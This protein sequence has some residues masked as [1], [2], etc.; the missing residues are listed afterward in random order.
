MRP[1]LHTLIAL[2][3]T[4]DFIWFHF[5]CSID[6]CIKY[7]FLRHVFLTVYSFLPAWLLL[8]RSLH[9]LL[10]RLFFF[11][12]P[13]ITD[14]CLLRIGDNFPLTFSRLTRLFPFVNFSF[15]TRCCLIT[16]AWVR[17]RTSLSLFNYMWFILTTL[18]T[19]MTWLY[20]Y[21]QFK[22][23][24]AAA[25]SSITW[26]NEHTRDERWYPFVSGA[27]AVGPLGVCGW[28]EKWF[29]SLCYQMFDERW[30]PQMLLF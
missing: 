15:D 24:N 11:I 2:K 18:M 30:P 8:L 4:I 7:N 9:P 29:T 17:S 23:I 21:A 3:L 5:I 27:N 22:R 16:Y 14:R 6:S 19:K 20:S 10:A 28:R 1:I 12:I 25:S 13:F 26:C